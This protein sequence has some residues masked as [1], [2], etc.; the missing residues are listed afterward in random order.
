MSKG[1][2]IL[3]IGLTTMLGILIYLEASAPDPVNWTKTYSIKDKIPYGKYIFF[4]TLKEHTENLNLIGEP[5]LQFIRDSSISGTYMFIYEGIIF[6]KH[7]QEEFLEWVEKGNT[8]FISAVYSHIFDSDSLK[9]EFKHGI[10][11]DNIINYK[12][13]SFANPNL[14]SDEPYIF[15]RDENLNYFSKIDTLNQTVLGYENFVKEDKEVFKEIN[16]LRIPYGKGELLFHS[17]PEVFSNFFLLKNDNYEYMERILAYLDLENEIYFDAY[18]DPKYNWDMFYSSP[19]YVILLNKYLK[20]GYYLLI[21]GVILFIV[22]EGKRKQ[23]A[24]RVISPLKNKSYQFTRSIAGMYLDQKDHTAIAHKKIEQFL[25]Y[26]RT[27]LRTEVNKVNRDLV[28]RL[29]ELTDLSEEEIEELFEEIR[30]LQT[31]EN[32][33]KTELKSLNK[34]INNFKKNS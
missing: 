15:E 31:K 33:S 26:V 22:F 13:Y 7:S 25:E 10:H 19:L 5:P 9:L 16:F 30:T 17:S 21:I 32:I 2:K 8:L 28:N 18:L 3:L 29:K 1:Y 11:G 23:K 4:E 27:N 14:K 6:E 20:W 12:E 24:I 34:K